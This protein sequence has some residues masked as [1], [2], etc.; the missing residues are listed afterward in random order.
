MKSVCLASAFALAASAAGAAEHYPVKPVR[1]VVISA[2]G[3][4]TDV[5]ARVVAQHMTERFGKLV[6]TDNRP[7][8]GGLIASEIT[9]RAGADGYTLLYANTTFTVLPSLYE[10][11]T[12]DPIRDFTAVGR[13]ALFPNLLVVNNAVPVKSVKELIALAKSQPGKLNYAGGTTGG[14]AHLSGELLKSMA[15][16]NIVHVP[17]KGTGALITAV[18]SGETQLSFATL[19]AV[20]P[21]VRA[22]RLRALAISGATRSPVLPELPTV[23]E[24]GLPGFDVSA[25]NGIVAPRDTPPM[26]IDRLNAELHRLA[27][28]PDVRER[29]ESQGAEIAVS[30]PAQF[31][32]YLK[33]QIAKWAKVV[34]FAGMRPD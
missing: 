3:G 27:A 10:K 22:G 12:Y 33:S 26:V 11:P 15:G 8:G 14:V 9:A 23:S 32:A 20:L 29:A 25:W 2:P 24:S 4:T 16:V 34:K 1:L 21:H 30:T 19:P 6:V 7:G 17:Y 5:L 13:V 18:L 31:T 28:L